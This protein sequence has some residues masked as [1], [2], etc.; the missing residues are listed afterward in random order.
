VPETYRSRHIETAQSRVLVLHCSDPRYQPHF[1]DF[2]HAGL[3][4]THYALIAVPGGCEHLS[5][6]EPSD[7]LR[8]NVTEWF[9]FLARLIHAERCILI[10]HADCR[11]YI[12]SRV[13]PDEQ[14]LKEHQAED[15]RGVTQEIG[16]RYPS[17]QTEIYYAEIEGQQAIFS[18]L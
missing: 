10:G 12:E 6:S 4:L 7:S 15:L 3:G 14:R 11:W 8:G 1:Q 9:D 13:E 18:K 5:A 17:I 2:L 16:R